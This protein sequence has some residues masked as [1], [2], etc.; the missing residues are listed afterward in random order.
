VVSFTR[1]LRV[2][3]L[4]LLLLWV[5][6]AAIPVAAIALR[7][8]ETSRNIVFWDEFDT[9]LDLI[10]R[11]DAG[12]G[13]PELIHR[14]LAVNNEHRTV[15]S[16]LLFAASY[17]LTGTVNFHV[18][19]AIG[20]LFVTGAC[21]LLVMSVSGWER[22][23][24]LGV[25]LAFLIFQLEHFESFL[26]SGASI[27]HFQ[28]VMLGVAALVALARGSSTGVVTA[29]LLG[30]LATFTL[31][32]GC[33]VWPVGAC[34]LWHQRR[35]NQLAAWCASGIVVVAAFLHGFEINPGHHI[36]DITLASIKGVVWYWLA[37]LGAPLTLGD[38]GFAP[39]PGVV[40]LIGL[41]V[42][43]SRGA[44]VRAPTLMFTVMFAV[45]ALAMVAFGRAQIA[46]SEINSRYL[47]LGALAW[48]LLIVMLLEFASDP[49]RPFR[50]LGW[51]LPALV[52]FNIS[53]NAAFAPLADGFV[54][55][56][57]RAAT[58]FMQYGEDGRGLTRLHP[59]PGHA[60]ALLK[61][62][63]ERGVYHLPQVSHE[64]EFPKAEPNPR[65]IT[66]FDEFVLND[67]AVTAGG[68]AMLPGQLSRRGHVFVV[69]QSAK[70]RRVYS[71]VTLQRPDVAKAY[72]EPKW[73]LSGFRAVIE[74]GRLPAEDFEV[75]VLIADGD[76]AEY[77]MT[78][79]R[80][81]LAPGKAA[82]AV[83]VTSAP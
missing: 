20:N 52:G 58:S 28:V 41:G 70:T 39:L 72:E 22:R 14:F 47:I 4:H 45:G 26:W 40:L 54:E 10:L 43:V 81:E 82:I 62:A 53:A 78:L 38:A 15:T 2:R 50:W 30:L 21:A 76:R 32:Q 64:A 3:R 37:L 19:G 46:S 33:V 34:L 51:I 11:I 69:L 80:L 23:I 57:D 17:W 35:W 18:I 65:I 79:N 68:W 77:F 74:R 66:H 7:V 6:I 5:V 75:G 83:R 42:V 1:P 24:R 73:R 71:T 12:A 8:V 55:V 44:L 67:R 27:D 60:E 56:R 13:W 9:A 61:M 59:K 16:R 29:G 49:G 31:A 48:A 25:V 63:A 36:S